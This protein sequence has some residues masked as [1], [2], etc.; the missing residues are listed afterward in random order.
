MNFIQTIGRK[1]LA[2]IRELDSV[3]LFLLQILA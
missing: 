2:F 3:C 1:T